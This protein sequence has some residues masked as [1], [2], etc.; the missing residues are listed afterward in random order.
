MGSLFS[1]SIY[2]LRSRC[3]RCLA[4]LSHAGEAGGRVLCGD[5]L[6]QAD[7]DVSAKRRNPL[8]AGRAPRRPT[9]GTRLS[10]VVRSLQNGN[11]ASNR[12]LVDYL[13]M[14]I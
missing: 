12:G 7:A 8:P 13:T 5:C 3:D 6:R 14:L 1:A 9:L 4:A 10:R 2:V 11:R